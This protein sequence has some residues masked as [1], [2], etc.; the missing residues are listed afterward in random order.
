M[1]LQQGKIQVFLMNGGSLFNNSD[2][3]KYSK[4]KVDRNIYLLE[5]WKENISDQESTR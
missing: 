4:N 2:T 5:G 1:T 3:K